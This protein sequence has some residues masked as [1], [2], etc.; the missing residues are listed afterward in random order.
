MRH[1]HSS[2]SACDRNE[3]LGEFLDERCLLLPREHQVAVALFHR[4]KR[5]KNSAANPEVRTPHVGTLFDTLKAKGDPSEIVCVHKNSQPFSTLASYTYREGR[6]SRQR[7]AARPGS[8]P[9]FAVPQSCPTLTAQYGSCVFQF[10]CSGLSRARGKH[11]TARRP[12]C[13]RLC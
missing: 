13:L 7:T 4:R 2:P 8:L 5:C 9:R 1:S 6:R 3:N 10:G 12:R 11:P